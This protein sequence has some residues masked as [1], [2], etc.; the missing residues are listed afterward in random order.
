M[1]RPLNVDL[2]M[3]G[4]T[5]DELS[6]RRE[7]WALMGFPRSFTSHRRFEEAGHGFS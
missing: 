6:E 4:A 1:Q 5:R 3:F 2:T 7:L